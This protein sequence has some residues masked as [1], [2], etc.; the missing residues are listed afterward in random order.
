MILGIKP[1]Y[2]ILALGVLIT[3]CKLNRSEIEQWHFND[4]LTEAYMEK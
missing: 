4:P 2:Q 3:G 1:M